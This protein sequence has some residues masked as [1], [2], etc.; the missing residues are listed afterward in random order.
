MQ[1]I[2]KINSTC[3]KNQTTDHLNQLILIVFFVVELVTYVE[4]VDINIFAL[5][6]YKL[7]L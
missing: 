5:S 4:Y 3:F 6:N 2:G 7:K 1:F